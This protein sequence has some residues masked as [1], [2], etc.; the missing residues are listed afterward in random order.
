MA[1]YKKNL[2]GE[3]DGLEPLLALFESEDDFV[4]YFFAHVKFFNPNIVKKHSN[5]LLGKIENG[6]S[7]PV[8]YSMKTKKYFYYKNEVTNSGTS[9]KS[10]K[11]R[12]DA[13]N[14]A[15]STD[16][17]HRET[18]IKVCIDKDGNYFVRNEI[19]EAIGYKVSQGAISD[20]KNYMISHIWEYTENPLF[21]TSLWNITL[22]PHFLAFILDKPDNDGLIGKIK[23]IS[24]A[25][26]FRIYNP[27]NL[28]SKY[29]LEIEE[30]H[31]NEYNTLIDSYIQENIIRFI[32]PNLS[33]IDKQYV[34]VELHTN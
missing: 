15:K 22:I 4:K 8:R 6:D 23:N 13:Q 17:F 26:C 25:I 30:T 28:M 7:I 10:F 5:L 19:F 27:T 3:I 33:I 34:E 21:F 14:F 31:F 20:I 11:N 16:L 9:K 29:N 2:N 12:S 18:G 32:E 1:W 24:K